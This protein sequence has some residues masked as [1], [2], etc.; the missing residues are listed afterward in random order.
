MNTETIKERKS[1]RTY[2]ERQ[3]PEQ[4]MVQVR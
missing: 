1:V 3:I 2:D 4:T